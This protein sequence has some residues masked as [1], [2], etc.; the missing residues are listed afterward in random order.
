M[1]IAAPNIMQITKTRANVTQ[2]GFLKGIAGFVIVAFSSLV[3]SEKSGDNG[4]NF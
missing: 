3:N 1:L 4:Q 2:T